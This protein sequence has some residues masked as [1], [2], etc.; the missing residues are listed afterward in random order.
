MRGRRTLELGEAIRRMTS[1][2]AEIFGIRDRGHIAPGAYA[3][4]VLFE[5]ET[6]VDRATYDAPYAYPSGIDSVFVNGVAAMRAGK[7]TGARP[8][9]VL[10]GGG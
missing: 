10:R 8:G 1:L 4:L 3:D 2:P 5:A 6:I 7:L 9:R